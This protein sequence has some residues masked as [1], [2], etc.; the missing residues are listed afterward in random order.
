[1]TQENN[2]KKSFWKKYKYVLLFTLIVPAVL[3]IVR[4]LRPQKA[5]K[6]N[7]SQTDKN[8]TN[9][10]K[11]GV[12]ENTPTT[13]QEPNKNEQDAAN[14]AK[15]DPAADKDSSKTDNKSDEV[16]TEGKKDPKKETLG[17]KGSVKQLTQN[18]PYTKY[19]APKMVAKK[20]KPVPESVTFYYPPNGKKR[21]GRKLTTASP[22]K[23]K[24]APKPTYKVEVL[25]EPK[26]EILSTETR[27]FANIELENTL[28]DRKITQ[29]GDGLIKKVYKTKKGEVG[30]VEMELWVLARHWERSDSRVINR[31]YCTN[32]EGKLSVDN[33]ND[34]RLYLEP[35]L[36]EEKVLFG[37][38][39]QLPKD[40]P[41]EVLDTQKKKFKSYNDHYNQYTWF[42]V[43]VKGYIKW[44]NKATNKKG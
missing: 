18:N 20:A 38:L 3:V 19:Y 14:T 30:E 29:D 39:Q 25:P 22:V 17:K 4:A 34:A 41:I 6:N 16:D 24:K 5:D 44:H 15:N 32:Q 23:I 9:Q 37:T 36:N 43:K 28:L 12:A 40:N 1:M 13:K 2:N 26:A 27:I 35:V 33:I 10:D 7:T 11:N 8:N 21:A 42:K 31:V